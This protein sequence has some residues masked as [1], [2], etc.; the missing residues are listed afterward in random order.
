MTSEME[1][2]VLVSTSQ[3]E[4]TEG[5]CGLLS[6]AGLLA[7]PCD[8]IEALG[9]ELITGAGV[10]LVTD[11]V[12]AANQTR[13]IEVLKQ[14]PAWSDIPIVVLAGNATDGGDTG[15]LESMNAAL[16]ELPVRERALLPLI[17]S[18]LRARRRQYEVRDQIVQ[19]QETAEAL[20]TERERLRITLAS[21]G[22]AV[23][24]TDAEGR[25]TFL[26]GVAEHLTGWSS[27]NAKAQPLPHVFQIVNE[28]TREEVES[29]AIRAL[30]EG[31]IVGLANHTLLIARDGTE[32]PIDDSAAPIRDSAGGTIGAILV[33]RDVTERKRAEEARAR[34]AAIVESSDDAIVSK[35]LDGTIHSWNAGAERLFGYTAAEA[36]GQPI[37]LIIPP[38][39]Q[40]E[41]REILARLS[42][43]ARIDHFETVRIARDGRPIDIS[44]TVSPVR[45]AEG[46]IVGAS[47]VAR[48]ITERKRTEQAL[49]E[50]NATL[51]SR[52]EERT[53]ALRALAVDLARTEHRERRRLS[54]VLHDQVQQLLVAANLHVGLAASDTEK[55]DQK[56][57]FDRAL[58]VIQQ[59]IQACRT[60]A[61]D[62]SPPLLDDRGLA[63]GLEWL[64]H[65][66][67]ENLGL[68]V[69]FA[70]DG[71]TD[72]EDGDVRA[73]LFRATQELL[74]NVVKHARTT[75]ATVRL[76]R[77]APDQLQV[78]VTDHGVGFHM[79]PEEIRS[80]SPDSFGLLS[81]RE[82][83]RHLGGAL[84]IDTAPGRGSRIR[85][86]VP[87]KLLSPP[88]APTPPADV[89]HDPIASR[90]EVT[91][92]LVVDDHKIL[93]EGL[94]VVLS[95]E[96]D[97]KVVGEAADGLQAIQLAKELAPDVILMDVSLPGMTG[98]AATRMVMAARPGVRIIGLSAHDDASV[99]QA[100]IEAGASHYFTKGGPPAQLIAAIRSGSRE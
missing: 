79:P 29:P 78:E 77:P 35:S 38:D 21:I 30:R 82:R 45:D 10:L 19:C 9:R 70:S 1:L 39:R 60:L 3:R 22:D 20:L 54:H 95:R 55:A 84:E 48:D 88:A 80:G 41:E 75:Q 64:A 25:I 61:V 36:V 65:R 34:L 76:I 53:A 87:V 83:V 56:Q 91:R 92:I 86:T 63:A 42:R 44:L 90:E 94:I 52:V 73:L 28:H 93:R 46:R 72:V 40:E 16:V 100:M 32:R 31:V 85:V 13:L 37:A 17:R 26:N 99:R 27:A 62:L 69:S 74:L 7:V 96:A 58:G 81:I 66:S 18:G 33:F 50:L 47:K 23:I 2:R 5:I 71:A 43:G 12:L 59:A 68:E 4:E 89:L 49:K 24:S 14:Q 11:E 6:G 8:G 67:H 15:I 57:S 98:I 97:F 51:E